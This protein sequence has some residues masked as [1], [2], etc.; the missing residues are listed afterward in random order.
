MT[1]LETLQAHLS[2]R[3]R[4][5]RELGRGG[6]ATVYLAHDLRHERPVALKVL[7][8]ELAASARRRAVPARDQARR[9]AAA[10][11]HPHRAT[12]PGERRGGGMP[13]VHHAVRRG[14]V[15]PRPARARG[16]A[17]AATTRCGS[18][19]RWPTRSATPTST[20]SSTATSSRRTSCSR[21][22]TRWWPTSASRR[23]LDAARAAST[24]TGDRPRLGTPAYMSP[25]QATGEQEV[26]GRSDV[27]ALGCVLYEML[28]GRAAVHRAHR[29][30]RS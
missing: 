9:P 27:Y 25:E 7:H 16:P 30:R 21:A 15:A 8:P 10:S 1:P 13:L 29:R 24:L 18:P 6:M 26:D 5:E 12:T 23:A 20:A 11:P 2:D 19:A 17:P 14:R 28:A 22:T 4:I 3:Y